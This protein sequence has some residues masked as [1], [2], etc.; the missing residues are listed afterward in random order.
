MQSIAGN[1]PQSRRIL[2]ENI[3]VLL[4][5]RNRFQGEGESSSLLE[6]KSLGMLRPV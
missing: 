6:A 3:G 4:I 1:D 2:C 5:H